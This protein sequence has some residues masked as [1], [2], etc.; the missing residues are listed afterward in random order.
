MH[1]LIAEDEKASCLELERTLKKWGHDVLVTSDGQAAWDVLQRA[2]APKLA[3]LDWMMP[4]LDGVEVCRRVRQLD[5]QEP[6]YLILLTAR[7]QTDDIVLGLESG[8]NDYVMKPFNRRELQSRVRCGERVI[9]LQRHLAQ[10]VRE[11]EQALAR[12]NQLQRLLPICSYCKKVR[13][14]QDYWQQV[15]TYLES[16]V[17]VQ[18]SHGICPDCYANLAPE[19]EREDIAA[20]P[21]APPPARA[22]GGAATP[23]DSLTIPVQRA[24][25]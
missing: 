19:L 2:D 10:R 12:I 16:Y 15:E 6:A 3:I 13:S 1:V 20:A 11:L 9:G 23:F 7:Q 14:D 24:L 25:T 21:D 8:A 18:F 17:D 22:A 5:S 4:G